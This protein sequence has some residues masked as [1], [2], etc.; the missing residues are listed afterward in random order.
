MTTVSEPPG[1]PA[2]AAGVDRLNACEWLPAATAS[3]VLTG[4]LLGRN[5]HMVN[6][7]QSRAPVEARALVAPTD[8]SRAARRHG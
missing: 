6:T 8:P 1:A 7:F 3:R 4:T 2:P 5:L